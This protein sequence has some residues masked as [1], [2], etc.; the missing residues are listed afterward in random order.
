MAMRL[1]QRQ[2]LWDLLQFYT[3]LSDNPI[4]AFDTKLMWLWQSCWTIRR[5]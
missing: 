1:A 4:L 2:D 5:H 3:F